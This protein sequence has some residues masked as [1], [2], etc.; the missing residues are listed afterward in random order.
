M[1]IIRHT[2]ASVLDCRLRALGVDIRSGGLRSFGL[3]FPLAMLLAGCPGGNGMDAAAPGQ[4]AIAAQSDLKSGP[5]LGRGPDLAGA[6]LAGFCVGTEI[7]GTCLQGYFRAVEDCFGASRSCSWEQ[8]GTNDDCQSHEMST[9]ANGASYEHFSQ[10]GWSNGHCFG[11]NYAYG[12]WAHGNL[13]CMGFAYTPDI[14]INICD[15]NYSTAAGRVSPCPLSHW[16]WT[17]PDGKTQVKLKDK[18]GGC[19]ALEALL[20]PLCL[21]T[22]DG[23]ATDGAP[24]DSGASEGGG[25]GG[26]SHDD[27]GR[28][29]GA[30]G[31]GAVDASPKG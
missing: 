26:G 11:N 20:N 17:C 18:Y 19:A 2:G 10:A 8:I 6:D 7:E 23:G 15:T 1:Q 22:E 13:G 27:G 28:D 24:R 31:G 21:A 9:W 14:A 5:D 16:G 29:G 3:F 12:T 4:D 25:K 30:R